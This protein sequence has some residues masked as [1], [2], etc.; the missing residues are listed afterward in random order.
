MDEL[1]V[2]K[3]LAT[4]GLQPF[5]DRIVEQL[6]SLDQKAQAMVSLERIASCINCSLL[7]FD[8]YARSCSG[9]N[10][11]VN[12]YPSCISSILPYGHENSVWDHNYRTRCKRR[13]GTEEHEEMAGQQAKV[14]QCRP[15][16]AWVRVCLAWLSY[17]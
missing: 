4:E 12:D 1:E 17:L 14:S 7:H 2:L 8:F 16:T 3:E 9:S 11:G 10:L 5:Y 13:R 15:E 6:G